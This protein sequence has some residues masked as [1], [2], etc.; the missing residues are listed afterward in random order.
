MSGSELA[1]LAD[2]GVA[3]N[4]LAP[5]VA[6]V[7]AFAIAVAVGS[8]RMRAGVADRSASFAEEDGEGAGTAVLPA[9]WR[10]TLSAAGITG[11]AAQSGFVAMH[12]AS[13]AVGGVAG[14]IG[15][16]MIDSPMA[17]ALVCGA[18]LVVGWWLPRSWLEGR[19]AQR[20]LRI[21]MDFP[22]MLDLLR[23]A[24]GGGL[25]LPAA[26]ATV[27]STVRTSNPDLAEEM[28]RIELEASMGIG[29]SAALDRAADRCGVAAFRALGSLVGQ[30]TRFGTELSKVLEVLS[31]SLQL[32]MMQSLEERAHGASVRLL[33]PLGVLLLPAT[34]V[35]LIGPLYILLIEA[36]QGAN[37]D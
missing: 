37:A 17:A 10:S 7:A 8:L 32:E 30:S 15:A 27:Q 35:V 33:V 21:A 31:D 12:I 5:I 3:A 14:A 20:Q 13:I 24:L 28:R 11:S 18:G 6:G 26:W 16:S 23:V 9:A 2:A 1:M 34:L 22:V 4:R 36:L 25:G 19:R 29:W